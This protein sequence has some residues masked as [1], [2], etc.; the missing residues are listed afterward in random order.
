MGAAL[1]SANRMNM[2]EAINNALDIMLARDPDVVLMGE[3]IG[4]FGGV[5]R[6]TAG[7][8][9]KHG[10]TRVFDTPISECGIIGA[11]VGM[12]ARAGNPV[13]RL[14]LPRP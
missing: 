11:G 6:A 4:Y 13:C 7:L 8:Q 3:D 5:F 12:A 10:K 14:Y 9:E 1:M 2:I